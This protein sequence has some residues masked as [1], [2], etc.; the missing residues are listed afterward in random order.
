[1][2]TEPKLLGRVPREAIHRFDLP[3]LPAA[4]IEGYRG[5]AGPTG[6]VSDALDE[7]GLPGAIPAS[8]LASLTPGS[9]I[10]GP[11]LTVRNVAHE[12]QPHRAAREKAN[13]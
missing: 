9:K 6:S 10:V 12:L 13:G 8:V 5:L 3:R 2:T 7:L 11:A 4:V 1:M